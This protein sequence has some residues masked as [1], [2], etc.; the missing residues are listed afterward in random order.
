M[1]DPGGGHAAVSPPLL[2]PLCISEHFMS[3]AELLI[4]MFFSGK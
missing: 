4:N 1:T 2:E 3:S